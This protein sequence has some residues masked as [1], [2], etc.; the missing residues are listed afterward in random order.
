MKGIDFSE[1]TT[2]VW[3]LGLEYQPFLVCSDE[4][5]GA[6]LQSSFMA[7]T[8]NSSL[9]FSTDN[10]NPVNHQAFSSNT[11]SSA[12]DESSPKTPSKIGSFF[13]SKKSKKNYTDSELVKIY[14]NK[15]QLESF[16]LDFESRFWFSYRKEFEP[17]SNNPLVIEPLP[18][19][20]SDT[21]S[22]LGS[23]S[24]NGG[25][26]GGLLSSQ[27]S[28]LSSG[29]SNNEDIPFYNGSPS[30]Y[31]NNGTNSNNNSFSKSN[32]ASS[33][34]KLYRYVINYASLTSDTG[35]GCM[36]RSGQMLLGQA[37]LT[38]YL[39]RDFRLPINDK[40]RNMYEIIR[41]WFFDTESAYYSIHRIARAGT[42]FG[43]K[44][45]EWFGPSTISYVLKLLVEQHLKGEFILHVSEQGGIYKDEILAKCEYDFEEFSIDVNNIQKENTTS[46][47]PQIE[48][49]GPRIKTTKKWKPLIMVI[50]LRLGLE[51][52]NTDYIPSIQKVFEMP[53]TLGIMG[54]KPKS[55]LYFIGY[56]DNEVIYLDPHTTQKS[57]SKQETYHCKTPLKLPISKIDP[58]MALGFLCSTKQDF[59][60]FCTLAETH[61]ASRSHP[62]ICIRDQKPQERDLDVISFDD[63]SE[64][65]VKDDLDDDIVIL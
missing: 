9:T 18:G 23:N 60:D 33:L 42:F 64:N 22:Y 19:G 46:S 11:S 7:T 49:I 39:G 25:G 54:G 52:F 53:Q 30:Q 10:P 29:T 24:S 20:P 40:T 1:T 35:W 61:L 48:C 65:G 28:L 12:N 41:S 31:Y 56:Q 2:P 38:H 15:L 14:Q 58:S 26:N 34:S 37:F 16:M 27:G 47:Y 63:L 4:Q 59:E 55:S 6:M 5:N 43:K 36:M 13:K 50:P 45:G 62:L 51:T 32:S 44:V 57:S 21:F 8:T 17:I 3:L